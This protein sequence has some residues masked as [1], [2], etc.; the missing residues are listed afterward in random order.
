MCFTIAKKIIAQ[1]LVNI[2]NFSQY[3]T[4]HVKTILINLRPKPPL[5]YF[6][7][8][9]LVFHNFVTADLEIL[10]RISNS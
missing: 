5:I 10:V 7:E 6:P 2:L 4:Q 8:Y 9:I 1:F 3:F